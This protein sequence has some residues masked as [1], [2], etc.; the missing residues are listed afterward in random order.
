MSTIY[1]FKVDYPLIEVEAES[2]EEARKLATD[3]QEELSGSNTGSEM[4]A[5]AELEFMGT[6]ECLHKNQSKYSYNCEIQN[7]KK[8]GWIKL[9]RTTIACK[10][11][12][13]LL[14]ESEVPL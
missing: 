1:Q 5:N 12:H 3:R 8:T 10:K 4:I 9:R 13:K 2:L 6:Y 7:K 11:C 14:S